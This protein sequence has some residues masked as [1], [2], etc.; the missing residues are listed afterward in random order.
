MPKAFLIRKNIS[1]RELGHYLSSQTVSQWQPV[2]P[3]P[4][5]EDE[6]DKD[7][8]LN[9]ST[10]GHSHNSYSSSSASSSSSSSPSTVVPQR[11]PVIKSP[12]ILNR[13]HPYLTPNVLSP[14]QCRNST[15]SPSPPP[16]TLL[17][18]TGIHHHKLHHANSPP[19]LDAA[20]SPLPNYLINDSH[21][22]HLTSSQVNHNNNLNNYNNNNNHLILSRS[23]AERSSIRSLH[24]P[25]STTSS[26]SHSSASS[27]L[28]ILA[29]AAVA[30]SAVALP[31]T[32]SHLLASS[33]SP[34]SSCESTQLSP[35]VFASLQQPLSLQIDNSSNSNCSYDVNNH[36]PSTSLKSSPSHTVSKSLDSANIDGNSNHTNGSSRHGTSPLPSQSSQ[37]SP[38]G[39]LVPPTISLLAQRLGKRQDTF[40][41]FLSSTFAL[42]LFMLP[43]S[44]SLFFL[45]H[46]T[47]RVVDE[48]CKLHQRPSELNQSRP[49]GKENL[50]S[51]GLSFC[52]AT[53][54]CPSFFLS[55]SLSLS[56]SN[57]SHQVST[58]YLPLRTSPHPK[59]PL[60]LVRHLH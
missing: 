19:P 58:L 37:M 49:P 39:E 38:D 46:L 56:F 57:K 36:H 16:P 45:L 18:P 7:Q 42:S 28:S 51:T 43:L 15:S 35:K 2:T 1:A 60:F 6:D 3:P 26:S 55:F 23:L 27:P 30:S 44:P 40:I 25:S 12:T 53:S 14:P 47:G 50:F 5:P 4:S 34:S 22:P 33:S 59:S 54:F 32:S 10:H 20:I 8:P 52:P 17:V 11:V 9:L 13:Y 21:K 29:S 41:F 24:S 48:R 31:L